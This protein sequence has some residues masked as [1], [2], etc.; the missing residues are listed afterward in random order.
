MIGAELNAAIEEEF[1]AP[2]P[3]AEQMRT[4]L[5]RKA[6]S[7]GDNDNKDAAA[8]NEAQPVP[9]GETTEA[10]RSAFLRFS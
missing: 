6:K 4:W 8:D 5:R 3:H 1:P 7:M 9:G 2:T 10:A